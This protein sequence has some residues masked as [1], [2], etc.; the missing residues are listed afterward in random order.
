[1]VEKIRRVVTGYNGEGRSVFISD[2]PATAIKEME[3]IP[4]L[5]LTDLWLTNGAPSDNSGNKD[6]TDRP[7]VLEPPT[8]GTVFRVVEF[9]PDTDW[10][11]SEDTSGAFDS[12]SKGHLSDKSSGDRM[13]HRTATT[14]YIVVLKGEIW[15]LV[16]EGELCLKQGDTLVQ[17]GTNHSWSVRTEEPCLIAAI[18][19]NAKAI[20]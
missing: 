7:V 17:R 11:N 20:E 15:V 13:L 6:A 18:L 1:M 16:D 19:V 2:G 10:Q 8:N 3:A 4:G 5:A 9:P 14:D 12:V